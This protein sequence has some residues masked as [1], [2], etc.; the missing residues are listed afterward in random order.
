MEQNATIIN[1]G[2]IHDLIDEIIQRN[3]DV[4][5]DEVGY[6]SHL[7]MTTEIVQEMTTNA[8]S[9]NPWLEKL[10]R[11]EEVVAAA[12]LHDVGRP[13]MGQY[14]DKGQFLHELVGAEWIRHNGI[15]KNIANTH[16]AINRIA[17][18]VGQHGFLYERWILSDD[19]NFKKAFNISDPKLLLPSSWQ[20]AFVTCAD[21]LNNGGKRIES[22][23]AKYDAQ[24]TRYKEAPNYKDSYTVSSIDEGKTR[25]IALYKNVSALINGNLTQEQATTIYKFL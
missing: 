18:M 4:L 17:E 16:E 10:L 2:G 21:D 1:L 3:P 8:I 6:R 7:H 11:V 20:A 5:N 19:E 12:E 15:E 22:L 25:V 24:A 14:P 23:E 9:N 13:L